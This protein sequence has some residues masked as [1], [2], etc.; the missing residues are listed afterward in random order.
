MFCFAFGFFFFGGGASGSVRTA[1]CGGGAGHV[2]AAV[3]RAVVG[4]GLPD[5]GQRRHDARDAQDVARLAQS[6]QERHARTAPHRPLRRS[7]RG[8][9]LDGPAGFAAVSGAGRVG[10]GDPAA[11]PA[12]CSLGRSSN[13]S[14]VLYWQP[15]ELPHEIVS[16]NFST[17]SGSAPTNT[18][19]PTRRSVS[20]RRRRSW[21]CRP[22][23]RAGR[24]TRP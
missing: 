17:S 15:Q 5:L 12:L 2:V 22:S 8:N 23:C 13:G 16:Y 3:R 9:D 24:A 6:Q 20:R 7:L 10:S 11:A 21:R 4:A 19:R 18:F 14:L 1:L